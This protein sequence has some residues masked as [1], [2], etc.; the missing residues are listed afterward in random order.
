MKQSGIKNRGNLHPL[1]KHSR[2]PRFQPKPRNDMLVGHGD[3]NWML[4]RWPAWHYLFIPVIANEVW[5]STFVIYTFLSLRTKCG[6]LHSLFKH[7][8][9]PRFLPKPRNDKYGIDL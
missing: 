5:Q 8:R 6:N 7:S 2:L 1:F 9:L 4:A 3:S